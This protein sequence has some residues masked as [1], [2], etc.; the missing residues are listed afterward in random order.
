MDRGNSPE[1]PC[2]PDSTCQAVVA[3]SLLNVCNKELRCFELLTTR[4]AAKWN[5]QK[6]N[7]HYSVL[8]IKL[9]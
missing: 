6:S 9:G 7:G 3:E 5:L 4:D 2:L 8:A 1:S